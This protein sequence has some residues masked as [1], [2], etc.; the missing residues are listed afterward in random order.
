M[1]A[2]DEEDIYNTVT[3]EAVTEKVYW[4]IL[5]WDVIGQR[6]LVEFTWG[7]TLCVGQNDNEEAQNIQ[8]LKWHDRN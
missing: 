8:N 6:M 4:D 5:K 3:M 2:E 1:A 7:M